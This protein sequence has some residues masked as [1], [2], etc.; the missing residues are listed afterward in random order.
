[1]SVSMVHSV[2]YLSFAT[3]KITAADVQDILEVSRVNNMAR[4]ITGIL[5]YKNN[6]F[7]QLLEGEESVVERVLATIE[8]DERHSGLVVLAREKQ[9]RIFSEWSMDFSDL[10]DFDLNMSGISNVRLLAGRWDA[11]AFAQAPLKTR[12][13][14]LSFKNTSTA[15]IP[16]TC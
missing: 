7:L 11:Q 15:A 2:V 1:M 6:Q 9:P 8:Q 12:R 4:G 5:F 16:E 10:N 14:L 3:R 13:L